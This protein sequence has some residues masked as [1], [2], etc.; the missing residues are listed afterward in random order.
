MK[1]LTSLAILAV[2][3]TF[4]AAPRAE[5]GM[6]PVNVSITPDGSNFRWTYAVVVTTDVAVHPGDFFTIYDFGAL[7]NGT[8]GDPITS[9]TLRRRLRRPSPS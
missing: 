2:L 5:A 3:A 6:I 7:V 1:R 8:G 4:A 9:G